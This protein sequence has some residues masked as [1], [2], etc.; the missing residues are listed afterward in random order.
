VLT[1]IERE[2][3]VAREA[4]SLVVTIPL[5][6]SRSHWKAEKELVVYAKA[7]NRIRFEVRYYASLPDAITASRDP[8]RLTRLFIEARNDAL[9]RLPWDRLG[10]IMRDAPTVPAEELIPLVEFTRRATDGHAH[11]F[12]AALEA[13]LLTGGV[14]EAEEGGWAT[15]ALIDQLARHGVLEPIKGVRSQRGTRRYRLAARYQGLLRFF[16]PPTSRRQ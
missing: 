14:S 2:L 12:R 3:V 6:A 4:G 15:P 11:A 16:R 7:D 1:E 8:V 9:T 10:E 13:L 5:D